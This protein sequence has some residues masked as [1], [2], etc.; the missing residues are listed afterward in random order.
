MDYRE[1][2]DVLPRKIDKNLEQLLMEFSELIDRVVNF[3]THLMKWDA[4][5]IRSGD[6]SVPPMLFLRNIVELGDAIS[7]LI[8][9][10][11]ID[12]CK[13]LLRSLLENTFGLK[14]M[15]EKDTDQRAL[16]YI[17]WN[18][19]RNL[20]FYNKLLTNTESGK[21]FKKEIE[22]DKLIKGS[23][24]IFDKPLLISQ[25]DNAENMLKSAKYIQVESEYKKA[26]VIKKDP[27]WYA[28]YGG[29]R[30][31]EGL[32]KHLEMHAF[33]EIFY[34]S[35]SGNVHATNIMQG[36]L[37]PN[38]DGSVSFVQIRY[39]EDAQSITQATINFLRLAFQS[40]SKIRVP[41]HYPEFEKFNQRLMNITQQ[42]LDRKLITINK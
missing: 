2:E 40:F 22:K 7:I 39:P 20:K 24:D 11:S 31:I 27:P 1:I 32:A 41:E 35:Y 15:L 34:R 10:S 5:K 6:E 37:I 25:R 13:P 30:T 18:T 8:R 9:S 23:L 14:Y 12:T 3:G 33:Y 4:D 29:P 36:K 42:L 26:S 28:L 21:V 17:L 38:S 16:S 19:H